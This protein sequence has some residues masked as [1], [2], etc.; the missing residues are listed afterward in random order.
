MLRDLYRELKGDDLP[1][2]AVT[3]PPWE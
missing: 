1:D 3:E 2:L